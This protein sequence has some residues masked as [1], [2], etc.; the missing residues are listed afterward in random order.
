[1]PPWQQQSKTLEEAAEAPLARHAVFV[2][3][4]NMA[5][6]PAGAAAGVAAGVTCGGGGGL[7]SDGDG[8]VPETS[9]ALQRGRAA[10]GDSTGADFV[11]A[12]DSTGDSTRESPG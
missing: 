4:T 9:M 7:S 5:S 12:R 1:M 11:N 2:A 6:K 10:F 8:A 3:D